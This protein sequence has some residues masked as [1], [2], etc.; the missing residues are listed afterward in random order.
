M[1]SPDLL[2]CAAMTT[3]IEDGPARAATDALRGN[4]P[5]TARRLFGQAAQAS[6]RDDERALVAA[7]FEGI[8]AFAGRRP[9][10]EI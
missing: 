7:S 9:D 6:P 2:F 4:D 1:L 3:A 5:G 10:G 8:D